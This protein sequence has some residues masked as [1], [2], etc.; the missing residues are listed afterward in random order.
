MSRQHWWAN[1][2]WDSYF[3]MMRFHPWY[4]A[5]SNSN[6]LWPLTLSASLTA[7][8]A[9]RAASLFLL[10]M[11]TTGPI[12]RPSLLSAEATSCPVPSHRSDGAEHHRKTITF[13]N[14][15]SFIGWLKIRVVSQ[16]HVFIFS[17]CSYQFSVISLWCH[18]LPHPPPPP[19]S[20]PRTTPEMTATWA[21]R[22]N[23]STV[24]RTLVG[25]VMGGKL[26]QSGAK[27]P[28]A[29]SP[30]SQCSVNKVAAWQRAG[31]KGPM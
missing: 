3:I 12:G 16:V 28:G 29:A 15:W 11:V 21:Q 31:L 20:P 18:T 10:S 8:S 23:L 22:K 2:K 24:N 1:Q 4:L 30:A 7:L 6:D 17:L 19:P 25:G 27:H 5:F 14:Y 26:G 9:S 13:K